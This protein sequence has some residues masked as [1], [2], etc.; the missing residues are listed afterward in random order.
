MS[1]GF[2]KTGPPK[3]AKK[4]FDVRDLSHDVHSPWFRARQQEIADYVRQ[5]PLQT[6]AVGCDKG[7]HRSKVMVDNVARLLRV[8]KFHMGSK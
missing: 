6:V 3:S 8:S 4:V 1:F 5:H 2:D 7:E